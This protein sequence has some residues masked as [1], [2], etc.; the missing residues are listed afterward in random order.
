VWQVPIWWRGRIWACVGWIG[1]SACKWSKHYII[2]C[3]PN[4]LNEW[5]HVRYLSFCRSYTFSDVDHA[6]CLYYLTADRHP[7]PNETWIGNSVVG[8]LF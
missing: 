7:N 4:T 8:V 1:G 2:F 3:Q 5:Y 6:T